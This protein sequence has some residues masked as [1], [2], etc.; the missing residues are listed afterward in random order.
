MDEQL[1]R[2]AV[3]IQK[4]INAMEAGDTGLP[5]RGILASLRNEPFAL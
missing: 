4:S 3:A 2:N 5:A 1:Q